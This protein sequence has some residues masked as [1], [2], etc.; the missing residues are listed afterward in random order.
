[1][2][3]SLSEGDSS[4]S[5]VLEGEDSN[6]LSEHTIDENVEIEKRGTPL[7]DYLEE[8][9]LEEKIGLEEEKV[10]IK[11]GKDIPYDILEKDEYFQKKGLI[12]RISQ[13]VESVDKR[14]GEYI[15]KIPEKR[16]S[17]SFREERYKKGD[18]KRKA[19]W[20]L[21]HIKAGHLDEGNSSITKISN[22]IAAELYSVGL[23]PKP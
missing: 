7:P 6:W 11:I 1:M 8:I 3:G 23:F 16:F 9:F 2:G 15:F 19:R 5:K 13:G 17:S 14:G 18:F 21:Y 22:E 20:A 10:R 4:K 12:D